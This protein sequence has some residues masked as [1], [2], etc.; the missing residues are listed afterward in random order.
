MVKNI[1]LTQELKKANVTKL[2]AHL[3][4]IIGVVFILFIDW[5]IGLLFIGVATYMYVKARKTLGKNLKPNKN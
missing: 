5:Y 2:L 1:K 4:A 3:V